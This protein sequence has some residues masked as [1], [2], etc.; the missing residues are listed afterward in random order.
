MVNSTTYQLNEYDLTSS[1]NYLLLFIVWPFLAF[2]TALANYSNKEARAIVYLFI[3]YYGLCYYIGQTYMDSYAYVLKLQENASLPMS[4]FLNIFGDL[5]TNSSLDII[6]PLISFFI[7]RFTSDYSFLFAA[8]AAL[9]GFFYLKSINLL[10]FHYKTNPNWNALI[11]LVF[12]ALIL[13]VTTINGVRMWTAAW[14]FFYG[15]YQV[16]IYRKSWYLLL[17]VGS[18]LIHWSFISANAIL[19]LYYFIGNRNLIYL[20][21]TIASFIFPGAFLP[22]LTRFTVGGSVQNRIAG[23]INPDYISGVQESMEQVRSIVNFRYDFVFYYFI[24][25]IFLIKAIEINKLKDKFENDLFSFILLFL[26]FVNFGH[27]IPS[28]GGRF[29]IVFLLFAVAYVLHFLTKMR[30]TWSTLITFIGLI[31]MTLYVLVELRIGAEVINA[32]TFLPGFGMPLFV[33]GVSL[34]ELFFPN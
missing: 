13:P 6:E 25:I 23:Y 19:L 18:C 31:P 3:V 8:Y 16:I 4:G 2:I 5:Y 11:F 10:Y 17:S 24:L 30:G 28:F 21:V 7:S 27:G 9:F 32:W 34:A 26:A 29:R 20:P 12:F 33:P 1:K 15:A 14:A 22:I